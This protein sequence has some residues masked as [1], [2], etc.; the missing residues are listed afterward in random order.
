MKPCPWSVHDTDI[1][2]YAPYGT[3]I[4]KG[5]LINL[6]PKTH[7]LQK[8]DVWMVEWW[9]LYKWPLNLSTI[10]YLNKRAYRVRNGF[11]RCVMSGRKTELNWTEL[12]PFKTVCNRL[13]N[14]IFFI[15]HI[16]IPPDTFPCLESAVWPFT[17]HVYCLNDCGSET[18]NRIYA[19]RYSIL[20]Y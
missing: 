7:K 4:S 15:I 17:E 9:Y 13:F 2:T 11:G 16:S 12:I 5:M 19:P 8:C 1:L 20:I 3:F 10:E 18:V 14:A 6:H